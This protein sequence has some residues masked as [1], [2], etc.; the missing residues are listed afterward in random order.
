MPKIKEI[1][2]G[3]N[4]KGKYR[5][6]CDL[7]PKKVKKYSPKKFGILSPKETGKS[8][9]EH[10]LSEVTEKDCKFI[11]FIDTNKICMTRKE[12]ED[13]LLNLNCDTYTWDTFGRVNCAK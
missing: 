3:T 1:L 10:V 5:E 6:I 11:R 13:Y 2:I 9:A 12:Y 8:S 4:N 7:L